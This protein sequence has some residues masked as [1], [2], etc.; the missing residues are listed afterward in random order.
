M[1]RVFKQHKL[2]IKDMQ[3]FYP[4][5]NTKQL[6]SQFPQYSNVN[7]ILKDKTLTTR[8]K[9]CALDLLV[10]E[11]VEN[12]FKKIFG[13]DSNDACDHIVLNEFINKYNDEFKKYINGLRIIDFLSISYISNEYKINYLNQKDI[14]KGE[15]I[16]IWNN[17][18]REGKCSLTA[19]WCINQIRNN[20]NDIGIS[21]SDFKLVF[22]GH[23]NP[24][25]EFVNVFLDTGLLNSSTAL[26]WAIRYASL[27]ML[28]K[29]LD[30]KRF[31]LKS[32]FIFTVKYTKNVE[33]YKY[34]RGHG[35]TQVEL[36]QSNVRP[37]RKFM[38]RCTIKN[39]KYYPLA[40]KKKLE[41]L[42]L[43]NNRCKKLDKMILKKIINYCLMIK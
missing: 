22:R 10:L 1:E 8:E 15:M 36:V 28:I 11:N 5:L 40:L 2:S 27:K 35:I 3:A 16:V 29:I 20:K 26:N 24:K 32:N 14:R 6:T 4:H 37:R 12:I 23:K 9:C 34:L 30:H 33:K 39:I 21:L 25:E 31:K 43:Y 41:I 38:F 18:I 17:C 7:V 19:Q 13:Y 42:L